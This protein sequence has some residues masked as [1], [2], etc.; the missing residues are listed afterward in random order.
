[1][2]DHPILLPKNLNQLCEEM[3]DLLEQLD[4]KMLQTLKS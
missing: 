1:M 2:Q 4:K 3:S